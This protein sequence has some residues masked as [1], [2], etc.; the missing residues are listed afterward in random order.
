MITIFRLVERKNGRKLRKDL[1]NMA[2]SIPDP[3]QP[4][5]FRQFSVRLLA[6]CRFR[7]RWAEDG[8][9]AL[10]PRPPPSS[11]GRRLDDERSRRLLEVQPH[12]AGRRAPA[13]A[14]VGARRLL[15]LPA[16][17]AGGRAEPGPL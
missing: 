9:R 2:A 12:A 5:A 13:R 15:A 6:R 7:P 16:R 11:Q 14:R 10:R 8:A 3:V 17:A 4:W 1:P